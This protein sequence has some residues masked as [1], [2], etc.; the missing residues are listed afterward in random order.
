MA[1]KTIENILATLPDNVDLGECTGLLQVQ[2]AEIKAQ[3]VNWQSYLQSQ[4]IS[5]EDYNFIL[6]YDNAVGNPEKRNAILREHGHQCA[7]TFLNLLGHICKDQT[8]QYLLILIE[9]ML[10]EKEN[11]RV[12]RDYAKKKRES[13]WAPFLNL[14]NRPD[15]ISVNLTA[16][17]LARLAC[18]GRQLMD[19]G[20]LQFYF[21]W[22]KDQL[23]RPNNQYIPTIARCLQLLLRV[24]EYRHAFLRVDGVSTLLSVLSSGVNFQCQYQLVFC[25]WV[26]TFNSD[27]AEKM[28]KFNLIPI[29]ADILIDT[30]KE[31]V[32]RMCVA[33]FRNLIEKVQEASVRRDNSIQ[34]VQ[35]KVLRHLEL[36]SQR[37]SS[38]EDLMADASFLTEHLTASVQD[39]SSF[40]E[41]STEVKSG[42]LEWS[43]VHKSDK[44]WRENASRL[45]DNN[46]QLLKILIHLI[47]SSK[48]PLVISV[49]CHDIGEYVRHYPRGKRV[50]ETLDGKQRVMDKMLSDDPSVRLY[51]LLTVQK[52]MVHNW[53]YLSKQ[54]TKER[55]IEVGSD[56]MK[57]PLA[58]R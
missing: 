32:V 45:N 56:I 5:Q 18:D 42:R 25:L 17:I 44:F 1:N 57:N 3:K 36:I 47:Q 39:L 34:M 8:I 24:D 9:D 49:A 51:A 20:D 2:A 33:T 10:T 40:D 14:L 48:D 26:L 41:Y 52:I 38:D 35:C 55:E 43:L 15:D 22:L 46:Y 29:L 16:W 50:I 11:C 31:K 58:S 4:M 6:A 12:F 13:V 27:I 54:M 19:G 53:D 23:K 28:G 30:E 7:K 37:Y 21:T